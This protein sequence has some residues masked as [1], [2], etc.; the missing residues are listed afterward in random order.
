MSLCL[1][2]PPGGGT[3]AGALPAWT[4][5]QLRLSP[6]F[7]GHFVRTASW[8]LAHSDSRGACL[9]LRTTAALAGVRGLRCHSARAVPRALALRPARCLPGPTHNCSSR[10]RSRATLPERPPRLWRSDSRA[11]C[12]GLRTTAALADVRELRCHAAWAAPRALAPRPTRCLPGP[13]HSCSPRRR[14]R[15]A[16]LQL[17]QGKGRG[18]L[19]PDCCLV[20]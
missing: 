14:S 4:H 16:L 19:G 17:F 10:R 8:A 3:Q 12:L 5:A 1:S 13:A 18:A 2:G 11:A 9:G 7:E 20:R 15:F 6:A